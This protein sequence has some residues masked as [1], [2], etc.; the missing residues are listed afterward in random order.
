M[1]ET[2][3]F[4]H[5]RSLGARKANDI[6]CTLGEYAIP[7]AQRASRSTGQIVRGYIFIFMFF[8]AMIQIQAMQWLIAPLA[9]LPM[10]RPLYSAGIRWTKAAFGITLGA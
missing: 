5:D 10:T 4:G 6:P 3:K 8:S 7:I 1:K 2:S 9:I